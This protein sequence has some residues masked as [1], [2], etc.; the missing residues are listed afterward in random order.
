MKGLVEL[1]GLRFGPGNPYDPQQQYATEYS[2]MIMAG[3][4]GDLCLSKIIHLNNNFKL[5]EEATLTCIKRMT[6]IIVCNVVASILSILNIWHQ[7][8][9]FL[10]ALQSL[11]TVVGL[12]VAR[13]LKLPFMV[14]FKYPCDTSH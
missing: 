11:A 4:S 2:S 13:R 9:T 14:R 12:A 10:I 7:T 8:L 3:Q 5:I 1:W 6:D